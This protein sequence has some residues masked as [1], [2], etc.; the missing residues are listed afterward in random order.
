MSLNRRNF[1][2][3]LTAGAAAWGPPGSGAI[4]PAQT[5][6]TEKLAARAARRGDPWIEINT[7]NLA[8]NF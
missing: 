3:V 1:L 4:S 6:I 2:G 5:P 8:W 7:A